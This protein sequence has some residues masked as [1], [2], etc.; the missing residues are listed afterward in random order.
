MSAEAELV[1]PRTSFLNLPDDILLPI[2]EEFYEQRYE[3]ITPA[4]PLRIAEILINKRIF[5]LA[6]P[7]WHKR[8]SISEAQLD[9]KLSGLLEDKLRQASLCDLKVDLTSS[10]ANLT[11]SLITLLP[12]LTELSLFITDNVTEDARN[13]MADRLATISSLRHLVLRSFGNMNKMMHFRSRYASQMPS[14]YAKVSVGEGDTILHTEKETRRLRNLMYRHS[15]RYNLQS[16]SSSSSNKSIEKSAGDMG[17]VGNATGGG[18]SSSIP[19]LPDELI[20]RIF[21]IVREDIVEDADFSGIAVGANSYLRVNR[22]FYS[23][24]RS[25]WFS[26]LFDTRAKASASIVKVLKQPL[27]LSWIRE[28]SVT[29]A[30]DSPPYEKFANLNR[31]LNLHK[32][33]VRFQDRDYRSWNEQTINVELMLRPL[34]KLSQLVNLDFSSTVKTSFASLSLVKVAPILRYLR[35]SVRECDALYNGLGTCPNTLQRL[36]L[37]TIETPPQHYECARIPWGTIKQVSLFSSTDTMCKRGLFDGLERALYPVTPHTEIHKAKH[38]NLE[39][40]ALNFDIS[41]KS[42]EHFDLR[43]LHD[44]FELLGPTS[45]KSLELALVAGDDCRWGVPI[46][47]PSL[48]K[49]TLYGCHSLRNEDSFTILWRIICSF[50]SLRILHLRGFELSQTPPSIDAF[51][52]LDEGELGLPYPEL[53][54]LLLYLEKKTQVVEVIY[55][56]LDAEEWMNWH[57]LRPGGSFQKD[58]YHSV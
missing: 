1:Q 26:T 10:H 38:I 34:V 23:L 15:T 13:A 53:C 3:S 5:L 56:D 25:S 35:L 9:S 45:I 28:V 17:T 14:R 33:T 52:P 42:E 48:V 6:R 8:L 29:F 18:H 30:T 37:S 20:L 49:L 39:S 40:L 12:R 46:V 7:L 21:E 31:L 43:D 41:S 19:Q 24:L 22:H 27:I 57:R 47:V 55:Q 58:S 50:P 2:L 32:L 54:A 11:R 16:T 4:T 44:L 51:M 36:E